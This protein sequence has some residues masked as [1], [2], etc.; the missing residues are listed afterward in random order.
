MVKM[1]VNF[2]RSFS[3]PEKQNFDSEGFFNI[4][5][6]LQQPFFKA[7]YIVGNLSKTRGGFHKGLRLVLSRE[8]L[9]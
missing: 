5:E 9:S 4:K 8:R 1:T 6:T 2:L 3:Y 7:G